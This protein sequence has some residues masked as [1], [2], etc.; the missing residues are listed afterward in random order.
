MAEKEA[1]EIRV[2]K[3]G[4]SHAG[5][6]GGAWKV[7][8]ADFMTAMM[9]FFLVMWIVGLSQNIKQSVAGYFQDPVGFMKAVQGGKAPFC[10]SDLDKGGPG[11]KPQEAA[12]DRVRLAKTKQTLEN[13][14]AGTPE[15]KNI[16][17]YVDIRLVN[18]G[19]EIDLLDAKES[20]FFDSGSAKVKPATK[21]L[22]GRLSQE[23]TK[24]PNNVIIEGH[25][26]NRP[27]AR[28]DGYTNWEL[29]ADR[30]NSARQIMESCGLR[31]KQIDQVRGYAAT[32]P[33]DSA[34]PESYTNRRV[35][36]IVVLKGMG[37]VPTVGTAVDKAIGTKTKAIDSSD[38]VG[39][40]GS[41]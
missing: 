10:V 7:A 29:S 40:S 35:S 38:P 36:I 34:H 30:A 33:R 19:L 13:I 24:L 12:A 37:E 15:F 28:S 5:H 18:E 14:V 25:T 22:L 39:I 23:L 41:K 2:I 6:H 20:M 26:D 27:L 32:H 1:A 17:Q 9:A 8:Y 4:K 21:Q 3:R 11:T 16:K 31:E